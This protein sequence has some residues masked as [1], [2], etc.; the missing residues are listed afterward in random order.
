[1]THIAIDASRTTVTPRT[2]TETYALELIRH[3]IL[4]NDA[5]NAPHR[6]TLYFRDAP[7]PDLLPSSAHAQQRIIPFKR[8]WTHLRLAHALSQDAPDV[9]FV[10]A[11]TLPFFFRG[12][13]VVTVHDVGYRL[14]PQA[15]P[16]L[17]RAYLELTTR[18]SA[19][20]ANIVFADSHATAQDLTR[21]YSTPRDKI[22]V[23]YPAFH[24]PIVNA[25]DVRA[26]YHL[27]ERYFL[28]I[29]TLQPRKNIARIVEAY[30]RWRSQGTQAIG[31]VL[32]GKKGWLF[33][34]SWLKEAQDV[35]ITGYID[36]A[37]KGALYAQ[38]EALV[39]PSLYEGF[40][41]PVLEAMAC[42]TPVI[43]SNTSSLPE[44]VG[45][46]GLL[47]NP[48]ETTHITQAMHAILDDGT[49]QMLMARVPLQLARFSWQASA[50]DA[51]NALAL[52]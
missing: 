24:A 50:Q 8:A 1:M 16:L 29:G 7:T 11:H 19:G 12:R 43:A 48:L 15:H 35:H 32:A 28:F 22:R 52:V 45:D 25:V 34:E 17:Q 47:V 37:D 33:D 30:M 2:G 14:F 3:I 5:L 9:V 36:D 18:Y 23:I 31:L 13:A 26:K 10:P 41:F 44:L 39:F 51:L 49:R 6:L 27:P 46:A 4:A 21:F 38:A 42:G 20:R 40:G